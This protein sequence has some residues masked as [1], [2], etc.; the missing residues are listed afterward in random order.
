MLDSNHYVYGADIIIKD[1]KSL[2]NKRIK[3]KGWFT[4]DGVDFL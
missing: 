2:N 3:K 1:C 4:K